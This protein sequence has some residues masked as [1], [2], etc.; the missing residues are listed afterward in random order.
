MYTNALFKTWNC[1]AGFTEVP[2]SQNVSIGTSANFR[3]QHNRADVIRWRV[4]G[5]LIS[6]R[7]PPRSVGIDIDR[8]TDTLIITLQEP[9]VREVVCVAQ[10][11]SG[12]PDEVSDIAILR[13]IVTKIIITH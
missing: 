4:D 8:D 9:G 7:N 6:N 10:F 11:D 5:E 3:C 2:A 1:H 12:S 13:G